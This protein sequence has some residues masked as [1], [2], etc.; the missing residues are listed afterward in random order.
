MLL[1]PHRIRNRYDALGRKFRRMMDPL[2]GLEAAFATL[3][4]RGPGRFLDIGPGPGRHLQYY[5]DENHYVAID[6][7]QVALRQLK[8]LR[9]HREMD[10]VAIVQ[11]DVQALPIEGIFDGAIMAYTLTALERP[12]AALQQLAP[13][14]RPGGHIVI[15]DALPDRRTLLR[16][17]ANI[18]TR[19][20][21]LADTSTPIESIVKGTLLDVTAK[22][23]L[24]HPWIT[25]ILP[26]A[27]VYTLEP[28]P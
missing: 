16:T 7:S 17:A 2:P 6:L 5:R 19:L 8:R 22:E 13:L 10:N 4:S 12:Q 23:P 11:G 27:R 24:E 28:Q 15:L 18:Y 25:L 14:I 26:P 9:R 20:V 1:N 3:H 21:N